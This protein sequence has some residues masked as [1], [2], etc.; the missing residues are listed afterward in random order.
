MKPALVREGRQA[1]I[2]RMPPGG[3]VENFVQQPRYPGDVRQLLPADPDFELGCIRF[4]QQ[5]VGISEQR[6]ALPQR[7]PSPF[8]VP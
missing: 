6:L 1:D 2:G 8:N 3:A 5:Q 7:S 4:L